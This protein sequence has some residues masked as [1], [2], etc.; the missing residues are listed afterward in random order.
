MTMLLTPPS[1]SRIFCAGDSITAS[2]YRSAHYELAAFALFFPGANL[3]LYAYGS[4]GRKYQDYF[5]TVDYPAAEFDKYIRPLT[6]PF[7]GGGGTDYCITL[8]GHNGNYPDSVT[9]MTYNEAVTTYIEDYVQAAG[10]EAIQMGPWPSSNATGNATAQARATATNTVADAL[11]ADGWDTWAALSGVWTNP[12]NWAALQ[13]PGADAL[14]AGPAGHIILAKHL[15]E[16]L[17]H[18]GFC[19]SATVTAAGGVTAV[20]GCTVTGGA[21]NAFGGA[22]FTRTDSRLPWAVDEEGWT[23]AIS[24]H[25][26]AGTWQEQSWTVTGLT[27]GLYDV[28]ANGELIAS[29]VSHTVLSAGWNMAEIKTGPT[30]RQRQEVL[31]CVRDKQGIG[32]VDLAGKLPNAGMRAFVS[33]ANVKWTAGYR[34]A[35]LTSQLATQI[36]ALNTL[37]SA[38]WAAAAPVPVTYSFR[39]QGAVPVVP[40]DRIRRF[41]RASIPPN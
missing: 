34:D 30:Y 40:S 18:D 27:A 21:V 2:P 39:L 13:S 14:H 33:N 28:Y 12:A 23:N 17:G 7:S 38:I 22:D 8:L 31:G 3:R 37:D 6:T 11:G 15:L 36:T 32:R 10:M 29:G 5:S 25:P 9:G 41:R 19:S 35:A 16:H 24:V 20:N 4:G 26:A 1:N